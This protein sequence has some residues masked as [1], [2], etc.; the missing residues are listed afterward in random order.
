MRVFVSYSRADFYL[1]EELAL[2]LRGRGI[3]A[4]LD[5]LELAP[6][7]DW[8][9][10]IAHALNEADGCVLVASRAAL[11]SEHVL[12]EIAAARELGL[13]L[14]VAQAGRAALPPGLAAAP[15]LVVTRR[16]ERRMDE[17][18]AALRGRRVPTSSR[19]VPSAVPLMAL[20]LLV[21]ALLFA[22]L[23]A[24]LY[25]PYVHEN[26]ALAMFAV[27][28]GGGALFCVWL[29]WGFVRRR[30]R[31]MI[32][33][34]V[35]LGAPPAMGALAA[36]AGLFAALSASGLVTFVWLA[37]TLVAMAV[38]SA[39]LAWA[40]RSGAVYRWLPT[41]DAPRWLRLQM[42]G[43]HGYRR[44]RAAAAPVSY[45]LHCHDIDAVVA[46]DL[47]DALRRRG[48]TP[49]AG[50]V[51]D[52]Q[53]C[54]VSNLTPA[55][56]F[57][58][59]RAAL[60]PGAVIV[61]AAA[62]PLE[63]LGDVTR[64]QWLDH[65]R[66]RP[67]TLANFAATLGG[68]AGRVNPELVPESL[69]SR[70]APAWILALSTLY[71]LAAISAVGL[72][73]TRLAGAD[74]YGGALGATPPLLSSAPLLALSVVLPATLSLV[75][76]TRRMPPGH[77]LLLVAASA[78]TSIAL[79]LQQSDRLPGL[80]VASV[81]IGSGWGLA[82]AWPTL[83]NWLPPHRVARGIER[84]APGNTRPWRSAGAWRIG[85]AAAASSALFLVSAALAGPS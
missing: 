66:R 8:D 12:A 28:Y 36:E 75:L 71:A 4:W 41:G 24:T 2:A 49:A 19:G 9:G 15:R 54:V 17:L 25:L 45:A 70:I 33:V 63:A 14:V 51:A 10:R 30:P 85:L 76:M 59:T 43:R 18:A 38:L 5:T 48:H 1:A 68:G 65:R 53:I 47:D 74:P 62:V 29:G 35:A 72:S 42:L 7:D 34:L 58:E 22:A 81:L 3:D 46:H 80:E 32:F 21:P 20:A 67:A 78:A 13:P 27:I 26:R 23:A 69:S 57:A 56:W 73:V 6:G 55:A 60:R 61:I 77:F 79:G 16:F 44:S 39:P 37:A 52:R 84:M 11:E 50:L 64:Y 83:V 82:A 40:V 31:R